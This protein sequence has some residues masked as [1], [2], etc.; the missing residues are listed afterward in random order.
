MD[1]RVSGVPFPIVA[2]KSSRSVVSRVR[3]CGRP[4]RAADSVA[5]SDA[6]RTLSRSH[7]PKS[8]TFTA[9]PN[10][11]K[12]RGRLRTGRRRRRTSSARATISCYMRR[13]LR[14]YLGRRM[15]A[16]FVAS[17]RRR[18][19]SCALLR[20]RQGG[21]RPEAHRSRDFRGEEAVSSRRRTR[22]RSRGPANAAARESRSGRYTSSYEPS[23]PASA[24]SIL[25]QTPG[26]RLLDARSF[27]N[28]CVCRRIHR[29]RRRDAERT[30]ACDC[31]EFPLGR[32]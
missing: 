2:C 10:M 26:L 14:R 27:E 18:D 4:V 5:A 9:A 6:H 22:S 32:A 25:D 3:A 29:R 1:R 11:V 12:R 24:R 30:Q 15:G 28:L 17:R 16:M 20:R 31:D 23:L 19:A 8:T 21:R 7:A 13:R